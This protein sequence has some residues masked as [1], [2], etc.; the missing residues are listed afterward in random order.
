MIFLR[1]GANS[2]EDGIALK[3]D[4][5]AAELKSAIANSLFVDG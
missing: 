4:A 3:V 2:S 5:S 1:Y